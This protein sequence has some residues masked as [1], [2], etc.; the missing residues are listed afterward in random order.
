MESKIWRDD[1]DE[2]K[3]EPLNV[4][5]GKKAQDKLGITLPELYITILKE[6]NGGSIK[7]DSYP[8]DTPNSWADDHVNVNHIRG[9]GKENSILDSQIRSDFFSK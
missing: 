5:M 3:L 4:A 7:F 1:A 9:I 8:S 6:Q 2:Y